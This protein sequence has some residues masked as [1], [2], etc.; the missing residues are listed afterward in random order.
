MKHWSK[1]GLGGIAALALSLLAGCASSPKQASST[2]DSAAAATLLTVHGQPVSVGEFRYLYEKN[3][4]ESDSLYSE[5]SLSEYL[6]LFTNFKLKV[7]AAKALAI[8]TTEAFQTELE[9]YRRQLVRPYLSNESLLDS[10]V[11]QAYNRQGTEVD[12]SH[13]LLRIAPDAPPADTLAAFQQAQTLYAQLQQG[14]DFQA[15]AQKHSQDPSARFN[16]GRL[17]Y[18]TSPQMIYPFENAAY[19]LAPEQMTPPFR[20]QFGYHILK[21]NNKRPY[22]GEMALAHI[23]VRASANIPERDSLKAAQEAFAIAEQLR[24]GADWNRL[25]Q[26]FTDDPVTKPHNGAFLLRGSEA[27]GEWAYLTAASDFGRQVP[28][29]M[30]AALALATPGQITGPVKTNYGWHLIKLLDK[31]TERAPL[32]Q[33]TA[34][35]RQQILKTSRAELADELLTEQLKAGNGFAANEAFKQ[36]ALAALD[37]SLLAGNWQPDSAAAVLVEQPLFTLAGQPVTVGGFYGYVQKNQRPQPAKSPAG[38]GQELYEAY[39]GQYVRDYETRNL[40]NKYP[41][42]GYL[43]NEYR[44]GMLLFQVMEDSVWNRAAS[45]TVGLKAFFNQHQD[46]YRW[47]ER[48]RADVFD[49][50]DSAALLQLEGWLQSK[51]YVVAENPTKKLTFP[52]GV[53][54]ITADVSKQLAPLLLLL[55]QNPDYNLVINTNALAGEAN[56]DSVALAR[57]LAVQDYVQRYLP[58]ARFSGSFNLTPQSGLPAVSLTVTTESVTYLETLFNQQQGLKLSVKSGTFERGEN[59]LLDLLTSWQA[60]TYTV[61]YEGRLLHYRIYEVLP[62]GPKALSETRGQVLSDYQ[63]EVERLWLERL[64]QR[65][66]ISVDQAQLQKLTR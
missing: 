16:N 64:R 41:E 39:V 6:A 30:E 49:L 8:D 34:D 45:D 33:K 50:T 55:R 31:R 2:P 19:S 12:A 29:F 5:A 20:T 48:A 43:L 53:Q 10:L 66:A 7:A 25:C 27:A 54:G 52:E 21:V 40:A 28:E 13:I 32:A 63:A 59:E 14:A 23:M 36:Q 47:K 17:G 26:Q 60:G 44:E 42:F 58:A 15:L 22:S 3:Y 62:P 57:H 35:L 38:Y 24:L 1:C 65:F 61:P 18:F 56:A 51:P 11:K 9:G 37:S 46:Q 4:A